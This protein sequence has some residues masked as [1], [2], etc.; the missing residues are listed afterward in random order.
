MEEKQLTIEALIE[1]N[2]ILQEE[3]NR[4]RNTNRILRTVVHQL[5]TS[6]ETARTQVA[7]AEKNDEIFKSYCLGSF[8]VHTCDAQMAV[9][10]TMHDS[11]L[12]G[13][14]R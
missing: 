6:L 11:G 8:D 2:E 1:S 14:E 3:V 13:H 12:T 7:I 10:P 9:C 5:R 4:L